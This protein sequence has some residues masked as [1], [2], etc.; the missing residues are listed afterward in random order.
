[1]H[2][3]RSKNNTGYRLHANHET[4]YGALPVALSL[5]DSGPSDHVMQAFTPSHTAPHPRQVGVPGP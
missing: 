4:P 5:T 3:Q 2:K 1:M